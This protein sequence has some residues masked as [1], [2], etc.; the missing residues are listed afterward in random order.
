MKL[1]NRVG[2]ELCM[3][4]FKREHIIKGGKVEYLISLE[5]ISSC[6]SFQVEIT[7]RLKG[8]KEWDY[9]VDST[10]CS[11]K[12]KERI[13]FLFW[14]EEYEE[15]NKL[16]ISTISKTIPDIKQILEKLKAQISDDI[17]KYILRIKI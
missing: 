8:E 6:E 2:K 3:K 4:N 9:E 10:I 7:Q 11:E 16:L 14:D 17:K 1:E 13:D 12:K 15:G 5:L